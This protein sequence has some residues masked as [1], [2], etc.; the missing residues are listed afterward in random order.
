VPTAS[1]AKPEKPTKK[2]APKRRSKSK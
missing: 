2:S 1:A